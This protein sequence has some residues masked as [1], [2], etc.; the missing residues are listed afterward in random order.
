MALD[1]EMFADSE[2]F[3]TGIPVDVEEDREQ[4]E[5]ESLVKRMIEE[6]I[7]W[8][9]EHIDPALEKATKYYNAEPYGNE[10]EGR[11]AVV[12]S[13]VRD[14]VQSVL[15][16]LMRVF[17]GSERVV[18]FKPFG[19]EDEAVAQQQTDYVNYIIQEDNP[20]FLVLY[21]ALKDA[22]VR[23]MG[24]VKA[25][26]EKSSRVVGSEHT[27]LTQEQVDGLLMDPTLEVDILDVA[28]DGTLDVAITR[29]ELDGR[30]RIAAVP[31]EEFIFSPG[32]R[33]IEDARLVGQV[34]DV[35]ADE[36][37][38]MGVPPDM[39]ERARRSVD[40]RLGDDTLDA[41]RR[42]DRGA[43]STFVD[44]QDDSTL[45]VSFAEVYVKLDMDDD[46]IAELRKVQ[47][48]GGE[49]FTN[50]VVD[51]VPFAIFQMDPEPHTMIGLS[52]AD[53]AA[54]IQL[55]NSQITRG[56][57]DS[58][59][60][61]LN[62]A[63]EVVEGMVN[64]KDVLN[65]EV[66]RIIRVRQAGQMREVATPFVGQAA[67]PVLEYMNSVLENRTGRSKAA[68][69]L[70]ADALQSSTKAAVAATISAAQQRT[71]L[72]ARVFAETGMRDLMKLILRLVVQHQDGPRTVRLRNQYV[73]VDPRHWDAD[74]DVVINVALGTG[75]VEEKLQML[76]QIAAKQ[77]Q[78]LQAGIPLTTLSK[79]RNTYAR[80]VELAGF[81]NSDEFFEPF[82]PE[83]EQA[84][85]QAQAAN[86]KP[87]EVE[88][89]LQIEQAKIQARLQ[90]KQMDVQVRLAQLEL[91]RARTVRELALKETE[92]GQDAAFE[93]ERLEIERETQAIDRL[94][95][96]SQTRIGE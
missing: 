49:L 16:S 30:I 90:E 68:A 81:R 70:D 42:I 88:A 40:Q 92:V 77:E 74:K 78:L 52:L 26:W 66:G 93:A 86:K 1:E 80:M 15:P 12:T 48:V 35:P 62:P 61:T 53:Y 17:F 95:T 65:P 14:V 2:V 33:S 89:L 34:R 54:D 31:P 20:G 83:Q 75:L 9:E 10:K 94:R 67:L 27:G 72:F 59:T 82:G 44:E 46:G 96:L 91:E 51:C 71:E 55:I 21:A 19:P 36:L 57:L 39:V 8:R 43:R 37:I 11:S 85:A 47:M 22:L 18:E 41:A 76:A 23:K 3:D 13:E 24:I 84:Y 87:D 79:L 28:A 45:P 7:Q 6:A 50:E 25:W 60:Q 56:M 73:E 58:L 38:A 63:V 64:M 69:G 4:D 5:V 29:E 32:A